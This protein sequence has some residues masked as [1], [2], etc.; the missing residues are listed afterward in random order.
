MRIPSPFFRKFSTFISK[1]FF[2]SGL[3]VF[4]FIFTGS[5][6]NPAQQSPGT[7][8]SGSQAAGTCGNGL[9]HRVAILSVDNKTTYGQQR[10]GDAV[11]DMLTTEIANT[12][13]F[14]LVE[15]AQLDK[16]MREQALGQSG[17]MDETAAPQ[18]GK[19]V[20]AEFVMLGS[21]TQFG[22]RTQASEGFFGDSKTQIATATV[23]IK[24][25]S[26][27]T[28]VIVLSLT[29]TG[30]AQRKYTSV[31]GM[32][33][34][35]G[36]DETL[37]SDALRVSLEGFAGKI[38]VEVGKTPWMCYVVIRGEQAFLDAG[39][40]SGIAVGQQ[41]NIFTKGEAILSPTTGAVLGYDEVKTG[42]VRVDRLL[43]VDG[44]AVVLVSGKLPDK[45]GVVRRPSRT[46]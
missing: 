4:L 25:V 8:A 9:K 44:A 23:D 34:S 28:G 27:E 12:G 42:V 20:G 21:V 22:V 2:T 10:I 33:T 41:Y 46:P 38:A 26:V 17:A 43:G 6:E 13:C 31:L 37:E 35:G 19:L 15:R 36:Y 16:V 1:S 5:A 24:L 14:V 40:R 39:T 30:R 45:Q 11:K 29:G 3:L 18:V 32:G 7:G